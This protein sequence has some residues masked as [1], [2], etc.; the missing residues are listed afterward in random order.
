MQHYQQQPQSF[1]FQVSDSQALDSFYSS[2]S[3]R[4]KDETQSIEYP[5]V[6][7]NAFQIYD[8]CKYHANQ[9]IITRDYFINIGSQIFQHLGLKMQEDIDLVKQHLSYQQDSLL[10]NQTLLIS[11]YQRLLK[12]E[13]K[14]LEKIDDHF[15]RIQATVTKLRQEQK[16]KM[17]QMMESYKSQYESRLQLVQKQ[18]ERIESYFKKMQEVEDQVR[19]S[20]DLRQTMMLIERVTR[21][22]QEQLSKNENGSDFQL[23]M[24]DVIEK[25][26]IQKVVFETNDIDNKTI[27]D[28]IAKLVGQLYVVNPVEKFFSLTKDSVLLLDPHKKSLTSSFMD[29]MLKSELNYTFL[30]REIRKTCII[31]LSNTS[32]IGYYDQTSFFEHDTENLNTLDRAVCMNTLRKNFSTCYNY[33]KYPSDRSEHLSIYVL[34]GQ[35]LKNYQLTS[36]IERLDFSDPQDLQWQLVGNLQIPR[37][38][39]HSIILQNKHLYVFGGLGKLLNKGAKLV[40]INEIER[41]TLQNDMTAKLSQSQILTL[42]LQDSIVRGINS[43]YS[44]DEQG[45]LVIVSKEY[46]EKVLGSTNERGTLKVH[47]FKMN[48]E[49][50]GIER[51]AENDIFKETDTSSSLNNIQILQSQYFKDKFYLYDDSKPFTYNPKDSAIEILTLSQQSLKSQ[52]IITY[53]QICKD[54]LQEMRF[55][56][57]LRTSKQTGIN[58][59]LRDQ[60]KKNNNG[61][62]NIVGAGLK[63]NNR[64]GSKCDFELKTL[65]KTKHGKEN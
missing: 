55:S 6:Q 44:I 16:Q 47:C 36:S 11:D 17:R 34:G 23:E 21:K 29:L 12:Y 38:N 27:D 35:D 3:L 58:Q 8:T 56:F 7:T 1:Y 14:E 49:D 25:Y 19:Y 18:S 62:R 37:I 65:K 61:M 63:V 51:I 50:F 42:R 15:N 60:Q 32:L 48:Q 4:R 54:D 41:L 57:D 20:R 46:Q 28:A 22:I 31:S 26:K 2:D 33:L 9:N 52:Q 53:E 40:E 59:I 43:V 10:Q 24:Q 5:P 39:A 13:R 45:G 64:Q 30:I